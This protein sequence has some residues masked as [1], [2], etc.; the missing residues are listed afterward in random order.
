MGT[1]VVVEIQMASTVSL[2]VTG[3]RTSLWGG[4]ELTF[5]ASLVLH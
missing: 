5:N 4:R 3:Q 1:L 2:D